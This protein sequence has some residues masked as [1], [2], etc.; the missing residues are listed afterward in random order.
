MEAK[1]NKRNKIK[2]GK[3]FIQILGLQP[4][5]ILSFFSQNE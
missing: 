1:I 4:K 2:L 5:L 3:I